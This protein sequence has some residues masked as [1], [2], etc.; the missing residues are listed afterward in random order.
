ML[1]TV[2]VRRQ[3]NPCGYCRGGE[4]GGDGEEGEGEGGDRVEEEEEEEGEVQVE[5]EDVEEE[6]EDV[7]EDEVG[8]EQAGSCMLCLLTQL[9]EMQVCI[10]TNQVYKTGQVYAHTVSFGFES[11]LEQLAFTHMWLHLLYYY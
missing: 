1:L 6:V 5:V 2:R 11:C 4:E 10:Y 3:R 8:G 7:V 9:T